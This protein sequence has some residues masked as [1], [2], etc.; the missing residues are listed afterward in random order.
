MDANMKCPLVVMLGLMPRERP[1]ARSHSQSRKDHAKATPIVGTGCRNLS[2]VRTSALHRLMT[3][4][5]FKAASNIKDVGEPGGRRPG[6]A[7]VCWLNAH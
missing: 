7:A 2:R 6:G 5:H 1:D 4:K 3:S